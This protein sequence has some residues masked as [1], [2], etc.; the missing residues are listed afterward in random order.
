MI[1]LMLFVFLYI[2]CLL[3]LFVCL[4]MY[5]LRVCKYDEFHN[6]FEHLFVNSNFSLKHRIQN[7][8][9]SC[10]DKNVVFHFQLCS[11]L[12]I[13]FDTQSIANEQKLSVDETYIMSTTRLKKDQFILRH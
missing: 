4:F 5:M 6:K 10:G 2:S 7:M 12:T 3:H 9:I 8:C 13:T 1:I 11:T